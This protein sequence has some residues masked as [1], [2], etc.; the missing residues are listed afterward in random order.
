M[1][2]ALIVQAGSKNGTQTL[3]SEMARGWTWVSSCAM[4]SS[5]ASVA[6]NKPTCLVIIEKADADLTEEDTE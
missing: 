1:Q 5:T 2:K 6:D 4:P 3:N